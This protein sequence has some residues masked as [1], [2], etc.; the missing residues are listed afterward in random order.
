MV[1]D[2][3]SKAYSFLEMAEKGSAQARELGQMLLTFAKGGQ[4][5][6]H[7]ASLTPLIISEVQTAFIDSNVTVEFDLPADMPDV[8]FDDLQMRKVVSNIASNAIEAMPQAG[9]LHVRALAS[10]L[11]PQDEV[12]LPPGE[13]LHLIFSDTGKGIPH[14]YMTKIFDPYFSSKE[15]GNKKGQ[16]LGLAV[17]NS[18]IRNHGGTIT[19]KSAPGEGATFHIWLPASSPK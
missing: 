3:G 8:R 12:P 9:K 2:P 4:T 16:G 7:S 15:M 13:Y 6:M 1:S 5:L 10:A 14:E 18:I 17:C 11:T 19:V